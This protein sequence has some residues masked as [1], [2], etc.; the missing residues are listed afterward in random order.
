M[1]AAW[2]SVRF[3]M[4]TRPTRMFG[5]AG[6][7]GSSSPGVGGSIFERASRNVAIAARVTP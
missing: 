3:S 6:K 7:D 2:L 1:S 4:L 5:S